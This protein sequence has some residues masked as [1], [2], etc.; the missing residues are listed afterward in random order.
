MMTLKKEIGIIIL[1]GGESSRM[2]SP[3]AFLEIECVTLLERL[4]NIYCSAKFLNP[5]I[6]LNHRFF[7]QPWLE[8]INKLSIKSVVL[9]NQFPNLG[10]SHSIRLGLYLMK[11]KSF[12]FLQN[13]DNP[14]I[15]IDLLDKMI[16][17]CNED[18]YVVPANNGETGHPILIGKKIIEHLSSLRSPNWILKDELK[19]FK[20][21]IIDAPYNNVLL[22]L[23]TES[24][25]EKY[26][27]E[28]KNKNK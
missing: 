12:C 17:A 26:S 15:S 2:K 1:C 28:L 14:D 13:I 10:R 11:D 8:T 9:K 4:T 5:V 22:N 24:D 23:N 3:K 20:R 7:S 19:K 6:I 18:A 25:W 16:S 27:E 21:I